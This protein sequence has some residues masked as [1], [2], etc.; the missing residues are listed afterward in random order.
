MDLKKTL[1]AAVPALL[2]APQLAFAA[3][4]KVDPSHS[5][6]GFTIAHLVIAEVEGRFD[7]FEATFAYDE[8]NP[9]KSSLE[10]KAYTESIN[11]NEKKRDEHLRSGDFFDAKKFPEMTFKSSKVV[12]STD[13]KSG[14]IFGTL[15]IRDVSKEVVFDVKLK[16]KIKDP[17]GNERAVFDASTKINRTDFGLKW[18]KALD[19]GGVVVGE[20]VT[21]RLKI[22]GVA[23]KS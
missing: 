3:N 11:T 6:V 19:A 5:S 1:R 23:D 2:L 8:K 12:P 14:Q 20:E 7:R 22:E 17:W 21:I 4:Y 9:S 10:A 15:T 18:N 13:G 16:G